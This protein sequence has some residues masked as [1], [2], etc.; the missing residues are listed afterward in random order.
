MP[1]V[2]SQVFYSR[3]CPN[4]MKLLH[5]MNTEEITNNS[6][7][8]F[9]YVD[10]DTLPPGSLQNISAVPTI[11]T[12]DNMFVGSKAFEYIENVKNGNQDVVPFYESFT[13]GLHWTAIDDDNSASSTLYSIIE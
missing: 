5:A 9:Q 1:K 13:D 12:P 3:R 4:S 7:H 2:T 6:N 10:I 8:A 11:K